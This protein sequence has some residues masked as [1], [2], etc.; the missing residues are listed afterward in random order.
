MVPQRT[1]QPSWPNLHF[2]AGNSII[3]L[4]FWSCCLRLCSYVNI[5]I[6]F[7]LPHCHMFCSMCRLNELLSLVLQISILIKL[8]DTVERSWNQH[9]KRSIQGEKGDGNREQLL[10]SF[11]HSGSMYCHA[12]RTSTSSHKWTGANGWYR[13]ILH[14][15]L[16]CYL[17]I[18]FILT[19]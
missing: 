3:L 11:I 13:P 9:W 5:Q 2:D 1:F 17:D 18:F 6:H 8:E 7:K 14:I 16:V 4:E 10:L 19:D 12:L 15:L